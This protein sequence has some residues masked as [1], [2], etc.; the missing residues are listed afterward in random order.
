[1]ESTYVF[2]QFLY[3]LQKMSRSSRTKLGTPDE[4]SWFD[5]TLPAPLGVQVRI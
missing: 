1:M 3:P 4:I 2:E 5:G